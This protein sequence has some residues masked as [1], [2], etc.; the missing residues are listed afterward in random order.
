M[1][2]YSTGYFEGRENLINFWSVSINLYVCGSRKVWVHHSGLS[3]VKKVVQTS[4][5]NDHCREVRVKGK[6]L[7]TVSVK[8]ELFSYWSKKSFKH[9]PITIIVERLESRERFWEREALSFNYTLFFFYI[10][11]C[12]IR[13]SG[14]DWTKIKK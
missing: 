13:M 1:F 14:W 4:S 9:R 6:I 2:C 3:L 5:Y 7:G 8:F 11:M 12:F 10:R